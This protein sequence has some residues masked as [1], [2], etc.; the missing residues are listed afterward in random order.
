MSDNGSIDHNEILKIINSYAN[1]GASTEQ[2]A[3]LYETLIF[4]FPCKE[5]ESTKEKETNT[6]ILKIISGKKERIRNIT[7]DVRDYAKDAEGEFSLAQMFSTLN[8]L[9]KEEKDLGRHAIKSLAK[10]GIIEATG[11]KTGIYRKIQS[12]MEIINWQTADEKE[13]PIDFPLGLSSL[14][15]LYP[16][17]IAVLAGASNVGKTSFMLETIRLNQKQHKVFYFNSEMGA[18]ELKIRLNQFPEDMIKWNPWEF[19][20]IE[21]SSNFADVIQPDAL[22]I[23]DFMEVYDEFYKIGAWIRDVHNKLKSGVAIIA[24]QKKASTK[25]FN[26]QFGRG[27]ELT[28]EKPRLYLSM[29]RG[30][31][32]IVKAKIWRNHETNPNGLIR[33]FNLVNGCKFIPLKGN[34]WHKE[35]DEK[36]EG[37]SHED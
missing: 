11:K 29:D 28:L 34:V 20:A 17:N 24:I 33:T 4:K 22:N 14:V 37:F 21:R 16:G 32:E 31:L 8:I 3:S 1:C 12:D 18:S 15:K 7:D 6:R 26:Q 13:Y 30:R 10:D 27:G 5:K 35:G 9:S 25:N 23:I 36:Y 19:T 2:L